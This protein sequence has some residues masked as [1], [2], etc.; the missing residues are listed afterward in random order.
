MET[1]T[2]HE[3]AS[4]LSYFLWSTMPDETLLR[5]ADLGNLHGRAELS[6]QVRE[7]PRGSA[8]IVSPGWLKVERVVPIRMRQT[9]D[10]SATPKPG[11]RLRATIA[12]KRA[13]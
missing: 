10:S 9:F 12:S 11:E 13:A 6:A 8:L 4:R 1:L 5:L 2:D 3:L 7:L